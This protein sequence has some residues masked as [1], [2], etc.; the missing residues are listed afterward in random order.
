MTNN[1]TTQQVTHWA[2][3]GSVID[4]AR[5]GELVATAAVL[6]ALEGVVQDVAR[7]DSEAQQT[8]RVALWGALPQ[9]PDSGVA[10]WARDTMTVALIAERQ[11]V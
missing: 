6:S 4:G 8:C 9:A 11:A 1:T 3:T 7:D 5:R 2:L 10:Q